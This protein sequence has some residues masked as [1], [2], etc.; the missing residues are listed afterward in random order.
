MI[1][2]I[3]LVAL[4]GLWGAYKYSSSAF[5]QREQL[6]VRVAGSTYIRRGGSRETGEPRT[7]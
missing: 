5:G 6:L 4:A 3:E 2:F 7:W 1:A